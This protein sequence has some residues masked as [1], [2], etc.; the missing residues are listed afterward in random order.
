LV[1]LSRAT[2]PSALVRLSHDKDLEIRRSVARN[3]GT[4]PG[5]LALL[6]TDWEAGV[7]LGAASNP[8]LPLAALDDL[9]GDRVPEI[10]AAAAAARRGR[11]AQPWQP[12][13][14]LEPD[15][16]PVHRPADGTIAG[17]LWEQPPR[18]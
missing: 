7:R 13:P 11:S 9:T 18:H 10:R 16:A 12:A 14:S 5:A 1:A 2:P 8:H 15:V 3:P 4:P 17:G 6:A